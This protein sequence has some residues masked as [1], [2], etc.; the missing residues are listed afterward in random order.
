MPCRP[1]G[2]QGDEKNDGTLKS[3]KTLFQV[4]A[5]NELKVAQTKKKI[6]EDFEGA[7]Q[8]WEKYLVVVKLKLME[9]GIRC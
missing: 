8:H 2:R 3:E 6:R 4:Y 5:P 9:K 7:K 1:W